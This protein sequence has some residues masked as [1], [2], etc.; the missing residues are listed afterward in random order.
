[1]SEIWMSPGEDVG[2]AVRSNDEGLTFQAGGAVKGWLASD[3][4]LVDGRTVGEM[5]RA[6]LH[7]RLDQW[8]EKVCQ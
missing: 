2:V 7:E 4:L 5:N 8:I 3:E 1:M 6:L